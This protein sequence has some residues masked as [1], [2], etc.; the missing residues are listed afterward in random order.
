M[1]KESS[2]SRQKECHLG[3]KTLASETHTLVALKA[4]ETTEKLRDFDSAGLWR[5]E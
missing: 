5:E 1:G 3:P 2:R 4:A